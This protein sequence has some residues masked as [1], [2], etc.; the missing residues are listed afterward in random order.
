M[1]RLSRY[2][3][4][5]SGNRDN[6]LKVCLKKHFWTRVFS[7]L[8][9]P[10]YCPHC[11][12]QWL[13]PAFRWWMAMSAAGIVGTLAML[14]REAPTDWVDNGADTSLK[15]E[16]QEVAAVGTP[17][18]AMFGP[19]ETASESSGSTFTAA[20]DASLAEPSS[21]TVRPEIPKPVEVPSSLAHD[22]TVDLR[23]WRPLGTS[24]GPRSPH[25]MSGV[26]G[27]VSGSF[28]RPQAIKFGRGPLA[29]ATTKARRIWKNRSPAHGLR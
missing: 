29:D 12:M 8:V 18:V 11:G 5:C 2:C 21:S 23:I 10:V 25:L 3:A 13:R 16:P 9:T 15:T 4:F 17:H 28:P 7:L 26:G 24:N 14:N 19:R 20:Y 1:L 22:V 6:R 27:D